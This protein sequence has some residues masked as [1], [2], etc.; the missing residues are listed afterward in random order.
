MDEAERC[1]RLAYLAGGNLLVT[2]T[3]NEVIAKT[4]LHTWQIIGKAT[5]TLLQEAKKMT[6]VTQAA[7]FG[8]RIHVCGYDRPLIEM[9]L[10]LL[11]EK[12]NICW[13]PIETT[14]ED[15]FI[16]LVNKFPGEMN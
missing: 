9:E 16:S 12:Q 6:G 10:T 15:A 14:L 5:T 8:N 7:L 1:T 4:K 3:V 13:E 11:S 2:G